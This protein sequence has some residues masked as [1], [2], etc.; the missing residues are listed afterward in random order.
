[1]IVLLS[2]GGGVAAAGGA[3][4]V[5][6]GRYLARIGNCAGCHTAPGGKDYAGGLR[7]QSEFGSLMTPN[8]TPDTETGIGGWSE[9]DFW[10]AM[11]NGERPDGSGL[12]PACPYPSFTH[13]RREDMDALFAYLRSV[14]PVRREN[15]EHDLAFPYNVRSLL[16]IWQALRFEPGVLENDNSRD[17]RWNRGRYLVEGLGHCNECHR[18]RDY[19]GAVRSSESAPGAVVHGWYAPSLSD[20]DQAGLQQW[21][22]PD[23]AAFLSSGRADG[24]AMLGPMAD[25][26]FES[27]RH[28]SDED[29]LAIA[30]YLK[31][32]PDRAV[33]TPEDSPAPADVAGIMQRGASIYRDGCSDCHGEKGEGTDSAVALAGNRDVTMADPTN[34]INIVR[35]GGFPAST[36]AN[37]FPYGMPPHYGLSDMEAAAVVTYIRRSWGNDAGVVSVNDLEQ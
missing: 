27:L 35:R 17:P 24:A 21:S 22:A 9:Q 19:L 2:L 31:S 4:T 28:L 30:T 7:L 34:V 37:P 25:V 14:P 10:N 6:K 1:M 5:E 23:A 8:I 33:D 16:G 15:T 3:S 13:V 26:V 18:Q 36:E 11:H 32:L 20:S 12:Y 29:A